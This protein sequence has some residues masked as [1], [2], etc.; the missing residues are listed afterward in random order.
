MVNSNA[1]YPHTYSKLVKETV[2]LKNFIHN[3]NIIV[4]DY[5]YYNDP[6]HPEHFEYENVRGCYFCKLNYR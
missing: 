6:N 2:F 1:L 3:P 4:G 5:T